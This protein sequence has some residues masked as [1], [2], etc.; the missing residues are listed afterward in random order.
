[1][2]YTKNAIDLGVTIQLSRKN[3]NAHELV[4][5]ED[6]PKNQEKSQEV[7]QQGTE[8]F[9]GR[10]YQSLSY[11]IEQQENKLTITHKNLDVLMLATDCR[12]KGGII[13]VSQFNLTTED[14]NI[15]CNSARNLEQQIARLQKSRQIERGGLSY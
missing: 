6:S 4:S 8:S 10:Y 14:K 1:M 7:N 9:Q 2:V 5:S 12:E 11:R 13:Q 15:I 3:E